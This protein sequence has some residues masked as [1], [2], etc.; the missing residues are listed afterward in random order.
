MYDGKVSVNW[1]LEISQ[2]QSQEEQSHVI[3]LFLFVFCCFL[4]YIL[5]DTSTVVF[6]LNLLLEV[7]MQIFLISFPSSQQPKY[8]RMDSISFVVFTETKIK[9][10]FKKKSSLGN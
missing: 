7:P 10:C 1:L 2:L 9:Y 3:L 4:I 6:L 5:C 8:Q